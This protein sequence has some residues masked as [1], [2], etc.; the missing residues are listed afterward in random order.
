MQ[1]SLFVSLLPLALAGPAVTKRAEPA[2]LLVSRSENRIENN[3]IVKLRKGSSLEVLDSIVS[4]LG[5]K[6]QHEYRGIFRGFASQLDTKAVNM[7]RLHPEVDYIEQDHTVVAEGYVTQEGSTWGLGRISHRKQGIDEY[8]YDASGHGAG[9]CAYVIDSGIEL[10]HP[11]SIVSHKP[12]IPVRGS[13]NACS[14][15]TLG[16]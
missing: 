3:Y 4:Q 8:T 1:L 14:N 2:P 16:I 7:L 15:H 9:V 12:P 13:K 11:V 10:D 5:V 6:P